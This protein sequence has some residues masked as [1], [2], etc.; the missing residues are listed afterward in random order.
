[1]TTNGGKRGN[2][3]VNGNE[4]TAPVRSMLDRIMSMRI[5]GCRHTIDKARVTVPAA[6][7]AR[8]KNHQLSIN[9]FDGILW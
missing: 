3:I 4:W 2:S 9:F 6:R 5:L 1:M 8:L 7:R